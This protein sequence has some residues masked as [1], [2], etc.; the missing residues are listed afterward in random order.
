MAALA[1]YTTAENRSCLLN[2]KQNRTIVIPI[3]K[4]KA[5]PLCQSNGLPHSALSLTQLSTNRH[6]TKPCEKF[7]SFFVLTHWRIQAMKDVKNIFIRSALE[8]FFINSWSTPNGEKE[9]VLELLLV[10]WK[11][12]AQQRYSCIFTRLYLKAR[13]R[14][15]GWLK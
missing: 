1:L 7:R 15:P 11:P 3:P 13:Q 5:T 10:S 6:K 2:A 8:R 4:W 9:D 14:H 12:H